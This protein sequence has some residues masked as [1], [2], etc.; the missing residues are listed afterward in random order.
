MDEKRVVLVTGG[1]RGIGFAICRRMAR[2][3]HFVFLASRDSQRGEDAA[4][5]LIREGL[6]VRSMVLDVDDPESVRCARAFVEKE[7]GRLDVLINNAGIF[8][9][10]SYGVPLVQADPDQIVQTWR[11]NVMGPLMLMQA[12]IPLMQKNRYGRVVN[13]SSGMGQ[14]SE[15]GGGAIAYRMSKAALNVLTRVAAAEL[16]AEHGILV[17]SMCPGWVRTDMGGAEAPRSPEEGADT[18]VWLATLPPNGPTGGLFR[19]RKPIPW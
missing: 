3:G 16:P 9:K 1:N 15:M 4:K 11:T 2:E 10:E 6:A 14:L 5:D 12:F 7:K 13:L 8:P 17:N 18:A 19:D